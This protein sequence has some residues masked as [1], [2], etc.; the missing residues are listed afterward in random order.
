MEMD[1]DD[2]E[3]STYCPEEMNGRQR[4]AVVA[5]KTSRNTRKKKSEREVH[6]CD[7]CDAKYTSISEFILL[8]YSA[9]RS[10]ID[11]SVLYHQIINLTILGRFE[12][13]MEKHS[14]GK[15]PYIC[16]VCG[17]HYKHKRACD[18]HVALHKGRMCLMFILNII[19]ISETH[20]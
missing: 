1:I 7:Q 8:C 15:P 2:D 13:H 14:D 11:F 4:R 12:A 6:Q 10:K 16:E 9:L 18:I 17:A 20:S 3:S 5:G 19:F